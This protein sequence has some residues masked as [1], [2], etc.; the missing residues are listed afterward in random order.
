MV[1]QVRVFV[2]WRGRRL[3]ERRVGLRLLRLL[4][5]R[6]SGMKGEMSAES[7]PAGGTRAVSGMS[8]GPPVVMGSAAL[9]PVSSTTPMTVVAVEEQAGPVGASGDL[10]SLRN[11]VLNALSDS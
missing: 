4:Q 6:R 3:W 1:R 10:D 2:P 5:A 8:G 11:A 9:D 7:V